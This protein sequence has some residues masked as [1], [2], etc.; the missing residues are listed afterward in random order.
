MGRPSTGSGTPLYVILEL[1]ARRA[2]IGDL[3][4]RLGQ[5]MLHWI[6]NEKGVFLF[7]LE[8]DGYFGWGANFTCA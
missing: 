7:N 2:T 5:N 1:A 3:G 6:G 4:G 8:F